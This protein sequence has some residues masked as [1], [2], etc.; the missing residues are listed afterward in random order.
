MKVFGSIILALI[1]AGCASTQSISFSP[2]Q[3][4]S[5]AVQSALFDAVRMDVNDTTLF[6]DGKAI[7]FI[8]IEPVPTDVAST[9]DFLEML[10]AASESETVRTSPLNLSN[11]FTGFGVKNQ[12]YITGYLATD[13][14]TDAILII[15]FTEDKFEE[16][17]ESISS[18]I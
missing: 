13:D 15:S 3:D 17:A 12:D 1:V 11:G 14:N 8:R 2:S 16:I 5:V 10:R 4:Y 9:T 6:R 18:G 7:G